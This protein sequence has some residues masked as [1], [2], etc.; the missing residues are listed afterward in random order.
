MNHGPHFLVIMG[1]EHRWQVYGASADLAAG[2]RTRNPGPHSKVFC[3][4]WIP[5][6][7]LY[8]VPE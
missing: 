5:G 3:F 2:S 1:R 6:L 8:A 4:D 7:A